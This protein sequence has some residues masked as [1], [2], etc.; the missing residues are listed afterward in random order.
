MI[1]PRVSIRTERETAASPSGLSGRAV[2]SEEERRA[3]VIE[4]T[5]QIVLGVKNLS[6]WYG[7]KRALTN[8]SMNFPLKKITALIGPSGC[9]KSTLLRCIN[10]MNDLIPTV[11]IEGPS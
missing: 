5:E 8:I 10:R 7:K 11:R 9:G 4:P 2:R 3:A 6:L 1:D